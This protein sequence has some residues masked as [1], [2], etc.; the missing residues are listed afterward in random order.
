ML[1]TLRNCMLDPS[2]F[3]LRRRGK[4]VQLEPKVFDVLM[5]LIA[6]RDRV[7]TKQELL[8]RFWPGEAVR[9]SVLP[10]RIAV[11][12]FVVGLSRSVSWGVWLRC[13]HCVLSATGPHRDP[14][15]RKWGQKGPASEKSRRALVARMSDSWS[16]NDSSVSG[17]V[18]R[19]IVEEERQP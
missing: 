7:V 1:F 4:I 14:L 13:G 15:N 12:R 11:T 5:H 16:R 10:R 19:R 8:D 6:H 9:D 18:H 2:C 17:L 3:E